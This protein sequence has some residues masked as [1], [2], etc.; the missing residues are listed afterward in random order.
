MPA[1]ATGIESK[2][3]TIEFRKECRQN[4][5]AAMSNRCDCRAQKGDRLRQNS[6]KN[7]ARSAVARVMERVEASAVSHHPTA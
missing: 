4:N 6:C 5:P 1:K 2:E 3:G 7:R